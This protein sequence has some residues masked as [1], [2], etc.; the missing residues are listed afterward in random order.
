MAADFPVSPRLSEE[1]DAALRALVEREPLLTRT[2]V[3]HGLILLGLEVI[4]ASGDGFERF[5]R[6]L[7]LRKQ[8]GYALPAMKAAQGVA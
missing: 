3:A 8:P 2:R 1:E 7:R 4:E 5:L 6:V